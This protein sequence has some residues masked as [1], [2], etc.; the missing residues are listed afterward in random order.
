MECIICKLQ[1]VG[2]NGTPFNVRLSN[3]RKDVKDPKAILADKNFQEVV[4]D[5]TNTQDS[6]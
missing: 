3:H 4:V 6:R 1:Y 2:K 5:L